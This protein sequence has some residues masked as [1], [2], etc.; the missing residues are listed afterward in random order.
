[1][2]V[3]TSKLMTKDDPFFSSITQVLETQIVDLWKLGFMFAVEDIDPRIGRL[4]L[5]YTTWSQTDG[6][7]D[8]R[9]K[10]VPCTDPN[11]VSNNSAFDFDNLLKGRKDA[12]FLCPDELES[13]QI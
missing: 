12:K 8:M 10:M 7:K 9:I 2:A 11:Y 13:L 5:D 3:Q 4:E 6:K 1:M